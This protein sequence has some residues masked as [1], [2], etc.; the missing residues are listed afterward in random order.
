MITFKYT[1]FDMRYV[2]DLET[3]LRVA[4]AWTGVAHSSY[5]LI[6][7]WLADLRRA[8]LLRNIQKFIQRVA[9]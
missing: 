3:V 5:A 2:L 7:Y 9:L 6:R 8:G 1:W 4:D